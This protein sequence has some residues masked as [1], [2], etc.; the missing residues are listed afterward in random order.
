MN[1]VSVVRIET[2]NIEK[3]VEFRDADGNLVL[4]A[5]LGVKTGE[6]FPEGMLDSVNQLMWDFPDLVEKRIIAVGD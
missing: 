5:T 3:T 4:S 1:T 2:D 6:G